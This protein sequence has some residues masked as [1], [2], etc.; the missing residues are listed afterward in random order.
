[1]FTFTVSHLEEFL[2]I[3]N[4]LAPRYL[5]MSG[6]LGDDEFVCLDEAG[7][8]V[9][10]V[11]RHL[12][13]SEELFQAMKEEIADYYPNRYLAVD[14]DFFKLS[15]LL[16]ALIPKRDAEC[17]AQRRDRRRSILIYTVTW[18]LNNG[19]Y[20]P[21]PHEIGPLES[22][23]EEIWVRSECNGP[24]TLGKIWTVNVLPS[25]TGGWEWPMMMLS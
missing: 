9:V 17:F 16:R 6:V 14:C 4:R 22:G 10:V 21:Y 20:I 2:R 19:V 7:E 23:F 11:R 25:V 3:S 8:K 18:D 5:E 1:M 13:F 24:N 15:G 12:D